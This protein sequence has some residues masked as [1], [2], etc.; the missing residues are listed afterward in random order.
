MIYDDIIYN[1]MLKTLLSCET[2]EA[3]QP[4]RNDITLKEQTLENNFII[5]L[6]LSVCRPV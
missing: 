3:Q 6:A 5:I 1:D 2:L 4:N